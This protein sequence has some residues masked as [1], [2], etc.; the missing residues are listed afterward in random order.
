[1]DH[2]DINLKVYMK[3]TLQDGTMEEKRELMNCLNSKIKIID[4]VVSV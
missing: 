2:E 3:Y 1:M 4:K